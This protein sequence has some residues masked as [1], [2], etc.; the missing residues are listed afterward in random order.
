MAK[1]SSEPKKTIF[2]DSKDGQFRTQR[3]AENNPDTTEKER[4][5]IKPPEPP[6]KR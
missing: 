4:V 5:R 2:R 6:K 1:Q 3:Y